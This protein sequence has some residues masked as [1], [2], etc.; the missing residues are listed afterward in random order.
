M[1]PLCGRARGRS[2]ASTLLRREAGRD[3]SSSEASASMAKLAKLRDSCSHWMPSLS[4]PCPMHSSQVLSLR[5]GSL[6]VSAL[7]S[8]PQ[9]PGNEGPLSNSALGVSSE[10]SEYPRGSVGGRQSVVLLG[11]GAL[12]K[13]VI[14]SGTFAGESPQSGARKGVPVHGVRPEKS[15]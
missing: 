12:G 14:G 2:L 6:P 7:L 15:A 10:F 13:G 5:P 11:R 3:P 8:V 9:K 4:S 1:C